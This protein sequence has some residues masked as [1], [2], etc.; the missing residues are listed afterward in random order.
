MK[1]RIILITLICS[2]FI[3]SSLIGI[4]FVKNV[5]ATSDLDYTFEN[6]IV[7]DDNNPYYDFSYDDYN[8][9]NQSIYTNDYNAT[10][11]FENDIIGQNPINWSDNGLTYQYIQNHNKIIG[12]YGNNNITQV[13]FNNDYLEGTIEYWILTTDSD[14]RTNLYFWD[15]SGGIL[16]LE[17]RLDTFAYHNGTDYFYWECLSNQW[18]HIRIEWFTNNKVDIYCNHIL[19]INK[20]SLMTNQTNGFD[21]F[22]IQLF[23]SHYTYLD[24]VGFSFDSDY[25][26]YD[27]IIP[28]LEIN[29]SIR[30]VDKYE[31]AFSEFEVLYDLGSDVFS[32]WSEI[33]PTYDYVNIAYEYNERDRRI[34]I[35]NVGVNSQT[36]G[37]EKEFY[38]DSGIIN[39]SWS[40]N[41]T[42]MGSVGQF[43]MNTYSSDDTLIS[44]IFIRNGF[45]R[46]FG[47][48][49][50][51]SGLTTNIVYEFNLYVNYW[52]NI[53]ILF[54]L[55][56]DIYQDTFFIPILENNKDG[57]GKVKVFYDPAVEN[58]M[59]YIDYVGIYINGSSISEELAYIQTAFVNIIPENY[60]NFKEFNL[61]NF[62]ILG[63]NSFHVS[64]IMYLPD[65][66]VITR[67]NELQYYNETDI[68]LNLYNF[69]HS[70]NYGCGNAQLWLE[71]YNEIGF[72]KLTIS[73]VKLVEG[74][75]EYPLI[76]DYAN[77]DIQDNYFYV[78]SNRL[79]FT[80][81]ANENDTL[82]Y[83]Q[84]KF[85]IDDTYA[86]NRSINFN[87]YFLGISK[88]Y[89]SNN[90]VSETNSTFPLRLGHNSF[91]Y[92]LPQEQIIKS[93]TILITDNNNNNYYGNS[94]GYITSIKLKYYP[95]IELTILTL[96][97]IEIMIPLVVLIIPTLAVA[98]VYGKKAIIPM[99]ILMSVICFI[100]NLIEIEMF[101]I[102]MLCLGSALFLQYKR[103]KE[104]I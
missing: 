85:G 23:D 67:I 79:Y 82:E 66:S 48:L 12:I 32:N 96:S 15:T 30:E 38:I 40:F 64:T 76:F 25:N 13:N 88:A 91:N 100:G 8:I 31:F 34:E 35:E 73:G 41:I 70:G 56:N 24:A 52:D 2:L 51:D 55:A 69:T 65:I 95:N 9:R 68:I 4:L 21:F 26:I 58:V 11:S 74:S 37:I 63:N 45:L 43:T 83:I 20:K 72:F 6:D 27:N 33:D 57:L 53:S 92:I 104:K 98:S 62:N 10:Y 22:R 39:I 87:A 77:V 50:L 16:S 84:A 78:K 103:E 61:F 97:L 14:K 101:F 18:Y 28:Y 1:K 81:T 94:E 5:I 46:E 7:F 86:I 71:F 59:V 75:N 93:F 89:F 54:Y 60:W 80:H 49:W 90:Y 29:D 19:E 42:N 17:I 36:S 99:L 47:G 102:M 3:I 44:S